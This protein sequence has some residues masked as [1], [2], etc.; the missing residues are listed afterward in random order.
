MRELKIAY[1]SSCFAKVWSNKTITFDALCD[2]LKNTIR[3]P[4]TVEEYPKLSKAERDRAKDKG[5]M[6]GGWLK[7][8]RRKAANVECRSMLTHDV[9]SADPDFLERYRML[10]QYASCLY[11]THSHTPEAPRYRIITPLTRDVSPEEYLALTRLLA[12]EWGIDCVDSCSYRAHQLMYWP[13]TPSNGEYVFERFDGAWLNPDAFLSAHPG[14]R[15]VS[16]LPTSSRESTLIDRQR[17]QQAD[18][19]AKPGIVGAF[20]RTYSIEEAIDTFLSDVYKPSAMAGRYDYVPADSSAGVVLYDGK[21][22]YSHHATDP[23]CGQLLNAFDLVR[24]HKFRDLDDKVAADTAPSKLP[25]YK[26]MCDFAVQDGAVKGTL[27]NERME[28]ATAEFENPDE[29]QK[30]LELDKQGHVKD[31]LTNIANIVRYDPGLQNIVFNELT[32]MLDVIGLLPWRQVKP[33]WGDAD[34]A[35]AKVYFEQVYGIWS[36]TKFKDALIAVVS[37][38]RIYH[39]IKQY[40]DTLQWDGT[41]RIDSLLIDYLGADDTAYTRA[42]TRKTLCAAVARVYEPGVKFDS[43]LVL[44]GPQGVGKSTLFAKLGGKWFSDSLTI[45]DM[46]DKTAAEK[47]QGYWILELGELAGIRKVDVE[48]VK[49]FISRT[50]DKFRQSYGTTVESHP[51]NNIIVGSTNSESGFLRDI[52]G[53]RRF[54]PVRVSGSS[55]LHPWDMKDIDQIWAEAVYAYRNGEELFLKDDVAAE[56]YAQQREAMESDD[57]EG[58]VQDYLDRL[59][60]ADWDKYDLYQ[61]RSYFGGSDFGTPAEGTVRRDRVCAMEIWCECFGKARE[62]LKKADSYEIEG[63]LYKLGGWKKYDGNANGKMRIPGYGVQKA[64]VRVADSTTPAT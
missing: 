21:F 24:I 34:L 19:L 20:C 16:L 59:L 25:S 43:I 27:A 26:A 50:D 39:P 1:G 44:N 22:A 53:N 18:P 14:W 42:A 52:T 51:R 40:F 37:S 41:E 23:A 3:T 58:V 57:R 46:K 35:C 55:I 10:N 29:W 7:Q 56:A 28:Q 12:K 36:P 61:R 49:S 32:C 54:W 30:L 31:T 33:G 62:A 45:S 48:T 47:L 13:T 8:G 15:D 64:Y 60:P 9:D 4:E 38:E 2:R 6:V 17:K 63:I 11:S 5:G